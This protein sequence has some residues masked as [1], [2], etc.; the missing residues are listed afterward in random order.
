MWDEVVECLKHAGK[1]NVAIDIVKKRLAERETPRMYAALGDLTDDK[2]WYDKAWELSGG[3]YARARAA[4]GRMAF[5]AG[6]FPKAREY[7]YEACEIKPLAPSAW[8]LLGTVCMRLEDWDLALKSFTQVVQQRP[9]DCDAWAN[10][11]SIHIRNKQPGSALPALN[12]SLK[13]RREN[14]RVWINKVS[15]IAVYC[16]IP[17]RVVSLV[18]LT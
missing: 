12:E 3:R 9:D 1:T 7:M 5:D 4:M 13:Q 18:A 10:V 17:A 6:D 16:A 2:A 11:G 15:I 14:W 8:F